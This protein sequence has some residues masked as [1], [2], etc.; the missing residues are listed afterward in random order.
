MSKEDSCLQGRGRWGRVG[1]IISTGTY[2]KKEKI[3]I[4]YPMITM[5][6]P[7]TAVINMDPV[8]KLVLLF[9][10]LSNTDFEL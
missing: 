4:T 2:V 10:V 8:A 6:L 9:T 1:G 5:L 3:V 7:I